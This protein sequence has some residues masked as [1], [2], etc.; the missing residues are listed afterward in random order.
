MKAVRSRTRAQVSVCQV[1]CCCIWLSVV[2]HRRIYLPQVLYGRPAPM[3]RFFGET[4]SFSKS[5]LA[6]SEYWMSC[7]RVLY[8]LCSNKP[9]FYWCSWEQCRFSSPQCPFHLESRWIVTVW[10]SSCWKAFSCDPPPYPAIGW[11]WWR[12][13]LYSCF[14]PWTSVSG[15]DES[16]YSQPAGLVAVLTWSLWNEMHCC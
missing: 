6:C 2:L 14:P 15:W 1:K 10:S 11:Y 3:D 4:T 7:G 9:V 13:H 12:H 5:Y 8:Q 16:C